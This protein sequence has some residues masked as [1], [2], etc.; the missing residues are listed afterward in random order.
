MLKR[1][2]KRKL[3]PYKLSFFA[4]F[5]YLCALK[6]A[7]AMRNILGVALF[8][9]LGLASCTKYNTIAK[10]TDYEYRYEL[11]KEYF[12][13]GQYTRAAEMF[14]EVIA[15]LKGTAY[16]EESLYLLA[17]SEFC[18]KNY[19]TA[20]SY[21]KKCY[22]SYPRGRYTELAHYYSGLSLFS[23]TRDP[24]LDQT[25]TIDAMAEF[26]N[27][28]ELF[29]YTSLKPATQDMLL[30][31]QDKLVDK[32]CR[33]AKLYFDLGDYMTNCAY[34]GSNYEACVVTAQNA[35]NDYPYASYE[36][37]EYLA[38]LILR[39]KYHLAKGSVEEKRIGRYRD[40]IDEYY[41]FIN[42]YP[43]S[44]FLK[45]AKSIFDHST[46]IVKKKKLNLDED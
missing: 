29:P 42:D 31:L 18:G 36:R 25:P 30:K 22:Q 46:E 44:K 26:N 10:Y 6:Y 3:S 4:F 16:G 8:A 11:A 27:F 19:E 33:S 21:F 45:E 9:L 15:P 12:V 41:S 1:R 5:Q 37:R 14:S 7:K 17:Q 24:R 32:E 34:G 28:L 35:L 20:A 39:S 23:Q 13:K 43:E 40:A 38:M 2:E